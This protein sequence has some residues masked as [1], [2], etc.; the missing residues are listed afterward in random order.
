M[1]TGAPGVDVEGEVRSVLARRAGRACCPSLGRAADVMGG[2]EAAAASSRTAPMDRTGRLL[3]RLGLVLDEGL[4][5]QFVDQRQ[6]LRHK[7]HSLAWPAGWLASPGRSRSMH[8]RRNCMPLALCRA[9]SPGRLLTPP[10]GTGGWNG[11]N[12]PIDRARRR[13]L[14]PPRHPREPGWDEPGV[15]S[16]GYKE[17]PGQAPGR[18]PHRPCEAHSRRGGQ[19]VLGGE[20]R[21]PLRRGARLRPSVTVRPASAGARGPRLTRTSG[22]S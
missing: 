18:C 20:G 22:G 5:D 9:G 19:V 1:D 11:G 10:R 15:V 12:P 14:R 16:C 4:E 6:N 17:V 3:R 2:A 13:G 7:G 21:Q 8:S